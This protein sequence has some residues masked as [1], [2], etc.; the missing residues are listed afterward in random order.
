MSSRTIGSHLS[1]QIFIIVRITSNGLEGK[2][3]AGAKQGL[4]QYI[5]HQSGEQGGHPV[6]FSFF[7]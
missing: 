1:F 4:Y 5:F 2:N 3:F 6:C 7:S